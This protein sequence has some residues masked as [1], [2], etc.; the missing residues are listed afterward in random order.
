MCYHEDVEERD[1]HHD[2]FGVDGVDRI[3]IE[4]ESDITHFFYYY[5]N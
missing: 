2:F 3:G 5:S 1:C 4:K